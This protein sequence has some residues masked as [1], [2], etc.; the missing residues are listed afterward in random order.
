VRSGAPLLGQHTRVVLLSLGYSDKEIKA[1]EKAGA[2]AC[3]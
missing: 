1:L 3:G 2:V